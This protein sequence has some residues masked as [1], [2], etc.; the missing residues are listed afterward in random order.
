MKDSKPAKGKVIDGQHRVIA[1][2]QLH[3]EDPDIY[4]NF[5]YANFIDEE[6]LDS[7]NDEKAEF[8][9]TSVLSKITANDDVSV[10]VHPNDFNDILMKLSIWKHQGEI[11]IKRLKHLHEHDYVYKN[12]HERG[13][14][15]KHLVTDLPGL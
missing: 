5:W 2:A 13:L 6:W 4:Q 12:K 1:Q 14:M 8:M 11:R 10:P 7:L 15:T 3:L 9:K